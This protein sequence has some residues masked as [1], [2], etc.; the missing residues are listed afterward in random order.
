MLLAIIDSLEG[1]PEKVPACVCFQQ[2]AIH[3]RCTGPYLTEL[4]SIVE[5]SP[6]PT[7]PAQDHN[8]STTAAPQVLDPEKTITSIQIRL[9]DGSRHIEKFNTDATIGELRRY[10]D[11]FYF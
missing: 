11:W 6:A 5:A 4:F 10:G 2:C 8:P 1:D 9:A 3:K 7:A